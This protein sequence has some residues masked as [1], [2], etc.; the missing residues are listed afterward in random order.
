MESI[1]WPR[2]SHQLSLAFDLPTGPAATARRVAGGSI[3]CAWQLSGDERSYFIKTGPP[4][5]LPLFQ[6]EQDGLAALAQ[7]SAVRVPRVFACGDV[8]GRSVLVLEWLE[9]ATTNRTSDIQLGI[10]LAQQ[11]H[12]SGQ[13]FGWPQ[14][15]FIGVTPQLNGWANNWVTFMRERR[16]GWQFELAERN[17]YGK[18]L[19]SLGRRL[20]DDLGAFYTGYEP[21]PSLLHGDLWGGN[22]ASIAGAPVIFDPA[23]HYGDRESD[24]AMTRLFGGFSKDF[25]DAYSAV[26]PLAA[27]HEDR[28]ALYQLYH[29]LN[30]LNM[31]G[32]AYL[33]Q[34]LRVT[35]GLMRKLS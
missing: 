35:N 14:D 23:V 8:N 30:H 29:L 11:H 20:L 9:L 34:V 26:W 33:G 18:K 12:I 27:G 6:S 3:S 7:A 2:F 4:G 19:A 13:A 21:S 10:L 25:Y 1:N 22:Y 24:I 15:N 16:L 31:F 17:G 32:E 28:V 5:S